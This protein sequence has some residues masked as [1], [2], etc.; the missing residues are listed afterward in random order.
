MFLGYH[1]LIK[2]YKNGELTNDFPKESYRYY[3][4]NAIDGDLQGVI[5]ELDY[6]KELGIDLIYLG[7]I[8]K[9]KT[10][11]GYDI[12]NYFSISE[13][14]SSNSEEDAKAIFKKLIEDAHKRGIKVII[15]LVLNHASKEFDF[16]SV[17]KD[18]NI[19]TES[20]RSP[21]EE[22]WQRS[23]LFWNLDDK[24]TREFLIRVGEYW[25]KNFELDGFRLDHALGLPL[26][27][28]EEFST[29][30]KKIKKDVVI[31]GEVWEDEG[32]KIKNFN[33][34]K[35]FKGEDAQRFTSLFDF[36]TYDTIKEVLGKKNGSLLDLY[37][38][39]VL[40]NQL[41]ERVFQLTYFIENHDLP[42][43]I[44]ICQELETFYIALGLLMALTGNV[45]LEYGNEIALKGDSTIQ[46]FHESGRVA[47][48]F[49]EDWSDL[50]KQ[51]FNY[52]K[53]LIKL[54]RVHPSLSS[55]SYEL[56]TSEENLLIFK[57]K[58]A[59]DEIKVVIYIG[60]QE[61]HL[62]KEY[63]DLIRNTKV[64]KLKKG[65]YYLQ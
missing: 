28:L 47:M 27:F 48:K 25:L 59:Y 38:Q 42:R 21:Q 41:N 39:I 46:N 19:K 7:P 64:L 15:D 1:I 22:R 11:H 36:A 63:L 2:F 50:E 32:D 13:N 58:A 20:P 5:K 44:D 18:L 4:K 54:R 24:E 37:N 30:M 43:F 52:C 40:S 6:L 26:N 61:Y 17:P 55:G 8:F 56:I 62:D 14:I 33:L 57:K 65:I 31:L 51:T 45:M 35:K 9:S 10:T 53:N 12:T 49:K 23:F 60:E 34:L 16:N 3:E 29:R